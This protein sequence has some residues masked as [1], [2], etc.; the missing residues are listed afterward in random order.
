MAKIN[1]YVF[2]QCFWADF[3]KEF[4]GRIQKTN[5][6]QSSL[7]GAQSSLA[8]AQW[9]LARAQLKSSQSTMKSS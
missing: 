6:A 1:G 3:L 9:S 8:R 5:W 7:A 2:L 4:L